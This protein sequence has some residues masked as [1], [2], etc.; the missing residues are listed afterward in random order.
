[1]LR[2]WKK[3]SVFNNGKFKFLFQSAELVEW[4]SNFCIL[5]KL[6]YVI[7]QQTP[8]PEKNEKKKYLKPIEG[9]IYYRL[10]LTQEI[11]LIF[12]QSFS[13]F[14]IHSVLSKKVFWGLFTWSTTT[15]GSSAIRGALAGREAGALHGIRSSWA[16]CYTLAKIF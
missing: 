5:I 9:S 2:L 4:K 13:R 1:M 14:K 8:N 7:T 12:F 16:S 15:G 11:S 6:N 10:F 3:F